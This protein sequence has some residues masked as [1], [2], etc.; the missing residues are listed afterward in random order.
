M[1]RS[2]LVVNDSRLLNVGVVE[3]QEW[4]TA[5]VMAQCTLTHITVSCRHLWW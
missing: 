2:K 3:P 4:G 1:G 5:T